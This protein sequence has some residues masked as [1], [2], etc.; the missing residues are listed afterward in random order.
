MGFPRNSTQLWDN[1]IFPHN[2]K[3]QHNITKLEFQLT[4][5]SP[6]P[7][8]ILQLPSQLEH[9]VS[10]LPLA[11]CVLSLG[12]LCLLNSVSPSFFSSS[13]PSWQLFKQLLCRTFLWQTT[14]ALLASA[15]FEAW[16]QHGRRRWNANSGYSGRIQPQVS[17]CCHSIWHLLGNYASYWPNMGK[18]CRKCA[19]IPNMGRVYRNLQTLTKYR[20]RGQSVRTYY[21]KH[22]TISCTWYKP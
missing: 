22:T 15:D 18:V 12:L 3:K 9:F 4:S 2:N 20:A 19:K 21:L 10:V 13:S 11:W 5:P 7:Q 6:V 1:Y 14:D 17:C 8:S 16:L